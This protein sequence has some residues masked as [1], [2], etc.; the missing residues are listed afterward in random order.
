MPKRPRRHLAYTI[1]RLAKEDAADGASGERDARVK[2]MTDE[3]IHKKLFALRRE[4]RKD[5]KKARAFCLQRVIKKIKAEKESL[6]GA[7][8][9]NDKSGVRLEKLDGELAALKSVDLDNVT[10]VA[11]VEALKAHEKLCE[12]TIVQNYIANPAAIVVKP[13]KRG[14]NGTCVVEKRVSAPES[15]PTAI[16]ASRSVAQAKAMHS[17]VQRAIDGLLGTVQFLSGEKNRPKREAAD[18]DKRAA[19]KQRENDGSD[20]DNSEDEDDGTQKQA[21]KSHTLAEKKNAAAKQRAPKASAAVTNSMF[22]ESL[23]GAKDDS[24][25]DDSDSEEVEWDSDISQPEYDDEDESDV[26]AGMK[27]RAAPTIDYD[28][29]SMSEDESAMS[30]KKRRKN[31]APEPKKKKNR[32]GQMARRKLHEARYGKDANHIRRAAE[33]YEK[34]RAA[35]WDG[36]YG[37]G[38][39]GDWS[40]RPHGRGGRAEQSSRG[41]GGGRGGSNGGMQRGN[42]RGARQQ[43][44]SVDANVHPSWA[45]QQQRKAAERTATFQGTKVRFDQDDSADIRPAH[46]AKQGGSGNDTGGNAQDHP[47]WE[48]KRR[49]RE[50]EA[51]MQ[52][53]KPSGTKIVFDDD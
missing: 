53:A 49:K 44:T 31:A 18:G 12:C 46:N 24:D 3:K 8:G 37:G 27:Q 6:A 30:S 5:A 25:E 13:A 19:A 29:I 21:A 9:D 1:R 48:A 41:H 10:D 51:A 2:R 50:Q 52:R 22:V 11:F 14:K 45:A 28:D 39:G 43:H 16:A 38:R 17:A 33:E 15:D 42:G 40:G 35:G 47:S 32:M 23:G 36:G 34:A 26:E 20:G 4:L 7:A